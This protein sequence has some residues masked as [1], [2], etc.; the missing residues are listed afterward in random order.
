MKKFVLIV[1]YSI[2]HLGA[3]SQCD[4]IQWV[5]P[6]F[7]GGPTV[8]PPHQLPPGWY[9]CNGTTSDT[10]PGNWG[11]N[12]P[13]TDGSQYIGMVGFPGWQETAT[14][15]LN[16]CFIAGQ[17]YSFTMDVAGQFDN[18]GAGSCPGRLEIWAGNYMVSNTACDMAELVWLSD[19]ID[20][21]WGWRSVSVA[22]TPSQ[23]YCSL[24]F[25][26]VNDPS[27]IDY[28]FSVQIDNLSPISPFAIFPL[29][30]QNESCAGTQN[31]MAEID[32]I[33]TGTP[34][35]AINWT[36][37]ILTGQG[38]SQ[39]TN[40]S[41]GY[42]TCTA[43][44]ADG[45]IAQANFNI[46][47]EYMPQ[48]QFFT[49]DFGDC[50][51]DIDVSVVIN[52]ANPYLNYLWSNGDT[53]TLITVP[54]GQTGW[55]YLSIQDTLGC[56]NVD[57]IFIDFNTFLTPYLGSDTAICEG[58]QIN[59]QVNSGNDFQWYENGLLVSSGSSNFVFNGTQSTEVVVITSSP[60][61]C[62]GYDTLQIEV[63]PLPPTPLIT[64][65]GLSLV[66]SPGYG[67]QWYDSTFNTLLVGETDS[68]FFPQY[69]G[70][71]YVEVTDSNGCSSVS[72]SV[73][74]IDSSLS[75]PDYDELMSITIS[76]NPNN[77]SFQYE[78]NSQGK[79]IQNIEIINAVG[80]V[81]YVVPLGQ[82]N[83]NSQKGNIQI[84]IISKGIYWIRFSVD[85][86][87]INE[88]MVIY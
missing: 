86:Q 44:D 38:T 36:P 48:I 84:P 16:H 64:Q 81:V 77:G 80:Q 26:A 4:T 71:F 59:L 2:F 49:S 72:N 65:N 22:F 30:S 19:Q 10:Q 18:S 73:F 27:C 53:D 40:L 17:S 11:I 70:Y 32:V 21:S 54:S 1:L 9:N 29:T 63:N 76:P 31:G 67:Y 42:Y 74:F 79:P 83:S 39:I 66:T 85:N 50:T 13:A 45:C 35:Y 55:N 8:P 51:S 12:L 75:V 88:R 34:P 62:N 61:I 37:G 56:E 15:R 57:S 43:T 60:G 47:L 25:K 20:I 68:I 33:T 6:S 23:N 14:Q 87:F 69:A 24:T 41:A 28:T 82:N 58:Q 46:E 3:F 78:I 52:P 5:N 7:E